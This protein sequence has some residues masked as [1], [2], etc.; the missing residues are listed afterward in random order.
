MNHLDDWH[1]GNGA[2]GIGFR[3]GI[4]DIIGADNHA[5]LFQRHMNATKKL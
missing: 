4:G 2:I 1:S 3:S 5:H